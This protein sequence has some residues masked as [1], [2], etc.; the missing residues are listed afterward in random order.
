[1]EEKTGIANAT[2]KNEIENKHALME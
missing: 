1:M 2:F